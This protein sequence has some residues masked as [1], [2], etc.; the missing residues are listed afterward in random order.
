MTPIGTVHM[1]YGP[2]GA[3]KSTF[4][5]RLTGRIGAVSF[6]IDDWIQALFIPDLPEQM[7]LEWVLARTQRCEQAIWTVC[8]QILGLGDDVVLDLGL[9]QRADRQRIRMRAQSV[10]CAVRLYFI[11][12]EQAIRRQRVLARNAEQGETF[13]FP[14]TPAMFEFMETIYEVPDDSERRQ[15]ELLEA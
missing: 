7:S 8:I 5:G 3:G 2:Q 11:D 14:V 12:A 13:S 4:S 6:S 1:V 9:M 10:G 15:S